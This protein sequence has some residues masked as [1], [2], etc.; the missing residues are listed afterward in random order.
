MTI[1]IMV[2]GRTEVAFKR[3]LRAFLEESLEGRMPRLD[4]F[5]YDGRIPKDEKLRR[6][7]ENLLSK[8]RSPADAVIALT[9]VYTGTH[10]FDDAADAKRKMLIS[11][12]A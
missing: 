10:D 6:T 1:A 4:M 2:E 9:D 5:P 11:P 8:G 7:V 12:P 3:H